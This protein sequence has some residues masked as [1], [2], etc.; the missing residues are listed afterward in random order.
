LCA[1]IDDTQAYIDNCYDVIPIVFTGSWK[2]VYEIIKVK[3]Y[4]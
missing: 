1:I 4:S 3:I 2:E